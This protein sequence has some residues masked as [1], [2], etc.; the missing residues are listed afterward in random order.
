MKE[1]ARELNP[2]I[3]ATLGRIEELDGEIEKWSPYQE[4]L[5]FFQAN[6]IVDEA[7]KR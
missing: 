2:D 7:K 3:A 1:S 4:R 6:G 5:E